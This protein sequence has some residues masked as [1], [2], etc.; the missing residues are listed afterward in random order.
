MSVTPKPASSPIWATAPDPG[1]LV[2]PSGSKQILGWI[3]EKPP[4]Q[5]FNWYMNLVYQWVNYFENIT[6]RSAAEFDSIVGSIGS[7]THT[8]IEAALLAGA[9]NILV[10][11]PII[12]TVNVTIGD[13][14]TIK[15]KP[16]ATITKG[17][18]ATRGLILDGRRSRVYDGRMIGFTGGPD[19]GILL[20]ANAKDC[21]ISGTMFQNATTLTISDLGANNSMSNLI[22]E[23]A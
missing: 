17:G 1:K 11:S 8:T 14:V 3:D 7:A 13:D 22:E 4:L 12:L 18:S 20:T 19:I 16:L 15:F 6:D 23:I 2:P 10:V 9:K 21:L 5:W